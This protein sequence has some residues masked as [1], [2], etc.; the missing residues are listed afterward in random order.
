MSNLNIFMWMAISSIVISFVFFFFFCIF[1]GD[2]KFY[3][4]RTEL[5]LSLS[6]SRHGN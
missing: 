2:I 6:L 1:R 5:G 3:G 4:Q